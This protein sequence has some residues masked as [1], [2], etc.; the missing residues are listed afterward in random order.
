LQK[1]NAI[2][3]IDQKVSDIAFPKVSLRGFISTPGR[4]C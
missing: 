3:Y 4:D 1:I 2:G